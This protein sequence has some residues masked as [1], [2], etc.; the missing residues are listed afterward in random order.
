LKV[1]IVSAW[2]QT[3]DAVSSLGHRGFRRFLVAGWK[4]K[5]G[6]IDMDMDIKTGRKRWFGDEEDEHDK[7]EIIG[8]VDPNLQCGVT[9]MATA[10]SDKWARCPEACPLYAKDKNDQDH[11]SFICIREDQCAEY[12]PTSPVADIKY[13][14][15]RSPT[16][17]WCD[18]YNYDGT[19]TCAKCKWLFRVSKSGGCE[20]E[21]MWFVY[22]LG[23]LLLV[24]VILIA[25]WFIDL[26]CRPISNSKGLAWGIQSRERQK[27][28]M[29]EDLN[30]EAGAR[31]PY[32]PF[33]TN[34][35]KTLVCGPGMTLHFNFQA[36]LIFWAL[37]VAGVYYYFA[38]QHEE[39]FILGTRKFGLARAN[40]ILVAWGYSTQQ[41]L[42]WTKVS[43][44]MIVYTGSFVLAILH[45]IRQV[46]LFDHLDEDNVTMKDFVAVLAPLPGLPG[47]GKWEE[48][49]KSAVEEACGQAVEG[50]SIA[51]D[52]R[53][54]YDELCQ[55]LSDD[56]TERER[57]KHEVEFTPEPPPNVGLVRRGF[58]KFE[59]WAFGDEQPPE[60]QDT[61]RSGMDSRRSTGSVSS[62]NSM[63]IRKSSQ[64]HGSG[65][66]HKES[67][68]RMLVSGA[69]DT[70]TM[71]CSKK[72]E[73]KERSSTNPE[74]D[75]PPPE[76]EDEEEDDA[77]DF[78]MADKLTKM[79]SSRHAYVVFKSESER[80]AAV[81][82]VEK[83]NG[84][85]FQ[86]AKLE[87]HSL[88]TEPDTILWGNFGAG[89]SQW[90]RAWLLFKGLGYIAIAILTWCSV[91]YQ[92]YCWAVLTFNYDNGQE[93]DWKYGMAFS[94][95]VVIG[96]AILYDICARVANMMGFLYSDSREATY[97]ALYTLS[98]T[99]QVLLDIVVTYFIALRI[100][101]GMH[102]RTEDGTRLEKLDDFSPQF[103]SYA[104]QRRLAENAF[105]YAFPSTF[106]IPFMIEPL[107]TIALPLRIGLLIVRS[108]PEIVGK[109]AEEWI[110]SIPFD[111]GRYADLL[112]NVVLAIIIF[113]FPG[114]FTLR[115]F[116]FLAASHCFIYCFDHW[117]VLRVIP[118]CNFATMEV[119]WSAQL[120]LA[121][122]CGLMVSCLIFKAN[123]QHYGFCLTG[124][125]TPVV[126][127][128]AFFLHCL[129]HGL[130][131][132][133]FVPVF[134]KTQAVSTEVKTYETVASESA[135]SWF[136]ANPVHCLR[137]KYIYK[138]SPY[139]Q[140][141]I[142]GKEHML[143]PNPAISCYFD[144]QEPE[145]RLSSRKDAGK[146]V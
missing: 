15:C 65:G 124:W 135:C 112:L 94:M 126:C 123:C 42:M 125:R 35:C 53:D 71:S 85:E 47:A 76:D 81:E 43:F 50:V 52:C 69:V 28:R 56:I 41:R 107:V 100:N 128:A 14:E 144:D 139:C 77:E 119:D 3:A 39:L 1:L 117:R 121:P 45:S 78:D 75:R 20:F 105:D 104:M 12:N 24:L 93:P 67:P 134:K 109:S 90:D 110:A 99:L 5:G 32:F 80:N 6:G 108:H 79:R 22:G 40:C 27:A 83:T 140:L 133:K 141:W 120:L 129:L 68:F 66:K 102:F 116:M 4:P 72:P 127:I 58:Y 97:M 54:C 98:C 146:D 96:N 73:E 137:S 138:H 11:C 88:C 46:R 7:Q 29:P 70:V 142:S 60:N 44:L 26:E 122:C 74:E 19:D 61:A 31:R 113:F 25:W 114:G 132:V 87:M 48:T 9:M 62:R 131:L 63:S 64:N 36:V 49:L 17:Q 37:G 103:E 92:P 106:L 16:V 59:D 23:I 136:N 55:K 51:W 13:G 143:Q 86:G 57:M 118:S 84:F 10:E 8:E 115:L 30:A 145:L 34:L 111:M 130:L 38:S 33:T 82:T 2:L 91:F 101:V 18:K 95:V 21:H 89:L